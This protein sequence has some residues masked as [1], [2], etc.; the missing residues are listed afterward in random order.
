M[1]DGRRPCGVDTMDR[2]DHQ[3]L[4]ASEPPKGRSSALA[5]T[6]F[7]A[8]NLSLA[9]LV[10]GKVSPGL[11]YIFLFF[12]PAIV[13]GH[14][15]RRAFRKHPGAYKNEAMAAYGLAGGCPENRSVVMQLGRRAS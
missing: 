2:E 13:A 6:S 3:P 5:I 4:K 1:A 11:V 12:A 15:A 9:G 8:G 10:L 14:M 7:V